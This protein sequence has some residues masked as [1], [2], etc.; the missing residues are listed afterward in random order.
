VRILKRAVFVIVLN[1]VVFSLSAINAQDTARFA[2]LRIEKDNNREVLLVLKLKDI[3]KEFRTISFYDAD[4]IDIVFD[5]DRY[6]KKPLLVKSMRNIHEGMPYK[7]RFILN[8]KAANGLF[9]GTI[10][11]FSPLFIDKLP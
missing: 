11:E 8:G 10:V 3:N 7:V 9:E 1:L 5:I 4:N 6:E 2:S